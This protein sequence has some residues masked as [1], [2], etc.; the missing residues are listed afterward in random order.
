MIGLEKLIKKQIKLVNVLKP[1]FT[2]LIMGN[3]IIY[4][5]NNA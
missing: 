5:Q 1:F 4:Y 3:Y 2:I